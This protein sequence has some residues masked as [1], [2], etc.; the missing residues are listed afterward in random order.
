MEENGIRVVVIDDHAVVREGIRRVLEGEA[1]VEVVAEGKDG[2]EAIAAVERDRPDVLVLDVAMPGKSW[3]EVIREV[4]RQARRTR[5]LVLSMYDDPEYVVESVRAGA[6]G[7][8]LKDSAPAELRRAVRTVHRGETYFPAAVTA[9]LAE[10][11]KRPDPVQP[12]TAILSPREREVLIGIAQGLTNKQ[13]AAGLG[14][15]HRTVETHRESLME[16]LDV[17][18]VAGLT[19]LALEEGLVTS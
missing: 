3:L 4:H 8:L 5:V 15:S 12:A 6:R 17:R 11:G 10:A 16:K 14:I 1:G 2:D 9:R 13:I 18:T 19:R 7:Y